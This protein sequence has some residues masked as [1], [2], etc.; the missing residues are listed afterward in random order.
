[1]R[2][3]LF[4]PTEGDAKK[5]SNSGEISTL[6][7]FTLNPYSQHE[8]ERTKSEGTET[9]S[10]ETTYLEYLSEKR[11]LNYITWDEMKENGL[12][13]GIDFKASFADLKEQYYQGKIQKESRS[14]KKNGK[15]SVIYDSI[16]GSSNKFLHNNLKELVQEVN[17]NSSLSSDNKKNI[18]D[19]AYQLG[20]HYQIEIGAFVLATANSEK[21]LLDTIYYQKPVG[22]AVREV[23]SYAN[24]TN[25]VNF[26][27]RERASTFK[28]SSAIGINESSPQD[29]QLSGSPPQT[30]YT[31]APEEHTTS[32]LAVL[33]F[34]IK[35]IIDNYEK[36]S[37]EGNFGVD[38]E[39]KNVVFPISVASSYA[40]AKGYNTEDGLK[41]QLEAL[42]P[43]LNSLC[44]VRVDTAHIWTELQVILLKEAAKTKDYK[45][46]FDEIVSNIFEVEN[47]EIMQDSAGMPYVKSS[48]S[49][50]VNTQQEMLAAGSNWEERFFPKIF[51]IL[52]ENHFKDS[53][54]IQDNLSLIARRGVPFENYKYISSYYIESKQVA[55]IRKVENELLDLISKWAD[56]L[57]HQGQSQE[58]SSEEKLTRLEYLS[59]M[60]CLL[61]N[62]KLIDEL[63]S[64][65]KSVPKFSYYF[66][67][68]SL[69][70]TKELLKNEVETILKQ[71]DEDV[72]RFKEDVDRIIDTRWET[73]TTLPITQTREYLYR[74]F[75]SSVMKKD[76]MLGDDDLEENIEKFLRDMRA[77]ELSQQIDNQ[78]FDSPRSESPSFISTTTP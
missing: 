77:L 74:I 45:N 11:D 35:C 78:I 28:F 1:M 12:C 13:Y 7:L 41:Q 54:S 36:I 58:A 72:V 75:F 26:K 18:I 15:G 2:N 6:S 65:L 38:F 25:D 50:W 29:L 42:D 61:D 60:L 70:A 73:P 37:K 48:S 17:N 57:R 49:L 51:N 24:Q 43:R 27:I 21:S 46:F 63:R 69:N 34:I 5:G 33:R 47:G 19:M 68:E 44:V 67:E 14:K 59:L 39:G 76:H 62:K 3:C 30:K 71:D 9:T 20:L 8:L 40:E 22:P 55:S 32:S 31:I 64:D 4:S 52:K 10:S 53:T 16:R 56:S 23:V 66:A